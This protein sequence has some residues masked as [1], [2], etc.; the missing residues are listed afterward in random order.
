VPFPDDASY[1]RYR[2]GGGRLARD[3]WRRR[4][5]DEMV[6][7]LDAAIHR[8]KPWVRFGVSP[9][10]IWRPGNPPQIAGFDQYGRLFADAR[11]WWREGWMDYLA[12]Q[13]YWP[14][15]RTEQSFPVL[16]GWWAG[17]NVRHRHL[18]PGLFSSQVL[19]TEAHWE[20]EEIV[21]QV[22]VL[23]GQQ[24]A[25]GHI[26][27]SM[28]AIAQSPDSLAPLLAG[29]VYREPAL[30]PESRWLRSRRPARPVIE[31]SGGELRF[32]PGDGQLVMRWI[33]RQR[34]GERWTT[35]VLPG[36]D[37]SVA[38]GSGDEVWISA[39]GRLGRIGPAAVI[40][41]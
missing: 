8:E 14:I 2:A 28:K 11:R 34:T 15:D 3:D 39:V 31:R 30:V 17:E 23:R 41:R 9:F 36:G 37:R 38:I 4:N 35:R 32:A 12:P 33:V 7:G 40:G 5:V 13:L 24:G 10:G 1:A 29:Q 20:A 19:P 25:T 26:H 21:R 6:R 16:L 27:F 22:Y 18:W